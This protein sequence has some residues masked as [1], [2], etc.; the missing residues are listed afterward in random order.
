MLNIHILQKK[1]PYEKKNKGRFKRKSTNQIRPI[2]RP[3]K[4][5]RQLRKRL[6]ALRIRPDSLALAVHP[7]ELPYQRRN[8]RG[9]FVVLGRFVQD[10]AEELEAA[11]DVQ[12]RP[13]EPFFDVLPVGLIVECRALGSTWITF[14]VKLVFYIITN[15]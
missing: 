5:R 14:N 7:L 15:K 13:D 6:V 1:I 2:L 4:H 8:I 9:V 10:P 12:E 3:N 11:R